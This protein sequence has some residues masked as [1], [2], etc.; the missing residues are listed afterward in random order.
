[1]GRRSGFN[2]EEIDQALAAA[3]VSED[4]RK[5]VKAQLAGTRKPGRPPEPDDALLLRLA[6]AV[7]S[8]LKPYGAATKVTEGMPEP[9]RK[10]T[11]DRI[12][13]KYLANPARWQEAARRARVTDEELRAELLRLRLEEAREMLRQ[14]RRD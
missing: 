6:E 5:K 13:K 3:G 9:L 1:L 10:A 2:L 7:T 4:V 12:Y 8:D 14:T 11:R